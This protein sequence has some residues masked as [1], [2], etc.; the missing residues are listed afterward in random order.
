MYSMRALQMYS[1]TLPETELNEKSSV[2]V[3]IG[4]GFSSVGAD[5]LGIDY[6]QRALTMKKT[7][8]QRNH[9]DFVAIFEN[10]ALNYSHLNKHL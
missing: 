2:L 9:P 6:Y 8:L 1:R 10:M 7:C 5:Q 3:D 4:I